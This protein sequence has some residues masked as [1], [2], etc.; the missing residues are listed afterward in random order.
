[1]KH[2]D[3]MYYH[4]YKLVKDRKISIKQISNSDILTDGFIKAFFPRSL[5]KHQKNGAQ[6]LK[7]VL[8]RPNKV[9]DKEI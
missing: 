8:Q 3:I 9:G 6:Q 4:I 7:K 5:K 2:I 1:M